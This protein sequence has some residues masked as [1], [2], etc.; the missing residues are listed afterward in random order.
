VLQ[1]RQQGLIVS[2]EAEEA[3]EDVK[4]MNAGN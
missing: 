1:G 2:H 3:V 4:H